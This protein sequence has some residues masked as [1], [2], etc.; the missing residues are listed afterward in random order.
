MM[1]GEKQMNQKL[2]EFIADTYGFSAQILQLS[3]ECTELSLAAQK[4]KRNLSG[5]KKISLDNLIE[6]MAD[7]KIMISQIEY[8]LKCK[9]EVDKVVENKLNRTLRRI[10]E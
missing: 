1:W 4:I 8:L 9:G 5:D 6:E 2:I 3:E 10:K 7:V